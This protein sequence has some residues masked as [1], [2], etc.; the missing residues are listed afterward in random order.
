MPPWLKISLEYFSL[1]STPISFGI[2]IVTLYFATNIKKKITNAID[3]NRLNLEIDDINTRIDSLRASLD[4]DPSYNSFS[5]A[6][7]LLVEI[8]SE[9]PFLNKTIPLK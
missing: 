5:G 1:F 8:Q 9:Y 6:R 7:V 4:E 3:R 2:S